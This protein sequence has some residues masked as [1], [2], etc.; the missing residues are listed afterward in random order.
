M[1]GS[2]TRR[3]ITGKTCDGSDVIVSLQV[4]PDGMIATSRQGVP[5]AVIWDTRTVSKLIGHLRELQAEALRGV[6]WR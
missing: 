3:V 5:G 4:T 1:T 6:V 2:G